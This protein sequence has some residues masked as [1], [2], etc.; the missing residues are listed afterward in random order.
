MDE[1]ELQ[2]Y[3]WR[4]ATVLQHNYLCPNVYLYDWESDFI[5]TTR[6]GFV[7]EYEIKITNAD[8]MADFKK[9]EKHQIIPNGFRD[10][11]IY[12]IA[13]IERA[14]ECEKDGIPH[15]YLKKLTATNKIIGS[16][17][18]YF[19]YICPEGIIKIEDVPIYAGLLITREHH[20]NPIQI[21]P[22]PR[23]HREPISEK[24]K[25]KILVSLS[26][27]YWKLRIP[28]EY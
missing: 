5:S 1:Y 27:K 18:N 10:P 25:Q 22:A 19:W 8:F 11:S 9:I 20:K 4:H 3:L 15:H 13:Y 26:Y 24:L 16:R 17:P 14:R 7:N 28:Q 6:A 21:K 12:E 23:L 2:N